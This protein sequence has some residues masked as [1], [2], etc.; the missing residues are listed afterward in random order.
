M[1]QLLLPGHGEPAF[2]K[3]KDF[4]RQ[5]T[6]MGRQKLIRMGENIK[7]LE[8]SL[9]LIYCS[10]ASDFLNCKISRKLHTDQKSVPLSSKFNFL[11]QTFLK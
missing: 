11:I 3:E 7:N 2:S 6:S 5:L 4:E 8:F 1:K 10:T 9:G